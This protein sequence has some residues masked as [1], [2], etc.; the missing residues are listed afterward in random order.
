MI[1]LVTLGIISALFFSSTFVLNRAMSLAGGHWVWTASLRFGFMLIFL[2]LILFITRG[3]KALSEVVAVFM[4]Y[5]RFWVLA[6]SIG[7]GVFYALISFSA[8]YAPGWIVATTWQTTILATPIVLVFF[9]RKVP[10]QGLLLTGLIFSGIVLVNIEHAAATSP[11]TML[12]GALPVFVAAF[13]YPIGNQMVWEA[14]LGENPRLP[15]IQDP[16]LENGFARVLLLTMGSVPFWIGLLFFTAPPSPS[17]GQL[18]STALVALFSGVI[19]TTIF[20]YARHLCLQ[21]YDIAAVDATQSM[22]VVFSLVGEIVFLLVALPG[23]LGLAG[24]GLTLVGLIAYMLMQ[25][26]ALPEVRA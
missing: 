7:F 20:L 23:G 6:G 16:I 11:I 12:S 13:A 19:A 25:N 21:A 18:F 1:R 5:W 4:K 2:F 8:A 26:R 10:T 24:V 14:R 3:R 22:E 17:T 15:H 9:G